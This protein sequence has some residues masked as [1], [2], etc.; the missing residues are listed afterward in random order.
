MGGRRVDKNEKGHCHP[1]EGDRKSVGLG[2][3]PAPDRGEAAGTA[4]D[5]A[6]GPWPLAPA[7]GREEDGRGPAAGN[8]PHT[9]GR[10]GR[11]GLVVAGSGESKVLL[12]YFSGFVLIPA[13]RTKNIKEKFLLRIHFGPEKEEDLKRRCNRRREGHSRGAPALA[14]GPTFLS[15]KWASLTLELCPQREATVPPQPEARE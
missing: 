4:G 6:P 2:S 15:I 5:P 7:R 11:K 8:G 9:A 3:P 1:A 13:V 14:V 12:F 10:H